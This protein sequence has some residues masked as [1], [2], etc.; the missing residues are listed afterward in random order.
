MTSSEILEITST[1][2]EISNEDQIKLRQILEIADAVKFA[3][4]QALQNEN[5]L[6]LRNSFEFVESTKEII[7]E[8][9][10]IKLSEPQ[11]ELNE[12][13]KEEITK[14]KENE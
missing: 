9:Q 10:N 7:D 14:D 5:D 13:T 12:I 4:Y 1:T 6:S 2:G 3:K 11:I 8:A